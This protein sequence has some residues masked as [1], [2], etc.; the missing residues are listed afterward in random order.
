MFVAETVRLR[1]DWGRRWYNRYFGTMTRASEQSKF[2]GAT[3]VVV[4]AFMA[5]YLFEMQVA[6]LAMLFLSFGD[7]SAGF[8]GLRYGR[9]QIGHKTV[10]GSLACLAVCLLLSPVTGLP[11]TVGISGAITATL[12]EAIPWRLLNDNITIPLFSGG[13]MTYLLAHPL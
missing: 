13:V 2:T 1:T 10:E 8:V 12:A 5:A 9:I 6:L 3:F 7:P 11:L 4:G